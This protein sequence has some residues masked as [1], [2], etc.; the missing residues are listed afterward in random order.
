M[1]SPPISQR[2]AERSACALSLTGH[3]RDEPAYHAWAYLSHCVLERVGAWRACLP[4]PMASDGTLTPTLCIRRSVSPVD[5]GCPAPEPG[6]HWGT[7]DRP[8]PC[9]ED[10]LRVPIR[11]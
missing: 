10:G 6:P 3:D 9:A 8:R 1:R 5:V 2:L 7:R 4:D 11:V